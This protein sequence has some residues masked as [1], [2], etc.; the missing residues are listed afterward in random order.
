MIKWNEIN[1]YNN[2]NLSLFVIVKLCWNHLGG[3]SN[4]YTEFFEPCNC[5]CIRSMRLAGFIKMSASC[6]LKLY[7]TLSDYQLRKRIVPII[8]IYIFKE[9]DRDLPWLVQNLFK[10]VYSLLGN[11][12]SETILLRVTETIRGGITY[13]EGGGW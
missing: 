7:E 13:C 6:I 12:K 5:L 10:V 3:R 9:N 11:W 8:W 4:L 2:I 1:K